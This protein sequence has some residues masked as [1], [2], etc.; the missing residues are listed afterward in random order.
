MKSE[1]KFNPRKL[2]GITTLDI[3]RAATFASQVTDIPPENITV[4]VVGGHS[5]DTIVPLFSQS[6]PALNLS[7]EELQDLIQKVQCGGD[8]VQKAKAGAGTA[9]LCMGYAAYKY[10][11]LRLCHNLGSLMHFFGLVIMGKR[12]LFKRVIC[13]SPKFLAEIV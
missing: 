8:E 7:R 12:V 2:F 13:T 5:R 11:S 3:V 10:T 1:N 4:P 9:T 6:T